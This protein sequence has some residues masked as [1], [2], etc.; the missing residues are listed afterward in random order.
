[1]GLMLAC[2]LFLLVALMSHD[3]PWIAVVEF[4]VFAAVAFLLSPLVFPRSLT[5]AQAHHRSPRE[6]RPIVY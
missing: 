1:M 3:S 4:L 6:G 5:A 2:G